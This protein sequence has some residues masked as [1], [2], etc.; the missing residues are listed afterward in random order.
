MSRPEPKPSI[1]RPAF[2]APWQAQVFAL[3][4]ALHE[5]G[6]FTWP[7]WTAALGARL[8]AAEPVPPGD[9][10]DD[11]YRQWAAALGD[12]LVARGVAGPETLDDLAAAWHAAAARTRHGAP[13]V[14]EDVDGAVVRAVGGSSG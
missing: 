12:V 1:E 7:E 5:S 14:L 11:Y 13:I 9:V 2:D 6:W 4:V 8:A 3:T 10:D